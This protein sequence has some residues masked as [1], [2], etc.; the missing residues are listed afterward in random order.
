MKAFGLARLGRDAEIR[1]TSNGEQVA[2]LA[3]AFSYGRKGS[4]GKRPT[5]WVDG[6]LWGKRAEALAPYLLKGGLVSVSLEDVHVETFEGKNGPGHK[7]AA[8]V[9]DVELA[10]GGERTAAP[11]PAPRPAPRP[12]ASASSGFDDMDSDIPF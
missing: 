10:G 9:V 12:P 1:T 5:Q 4:D 11:A 3:L 2:T 8:R 7:L 6:A